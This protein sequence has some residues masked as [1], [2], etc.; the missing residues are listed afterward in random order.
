MTARRMY[1]WVSIPEMAQWLDLETNEAV[2]LL[3]LIGLRWR[4]A[5]EVRFRS[6]VFQDGIA[7]RVE[8]EDGAEA[9]QWNLFAIRAI[10]NDSYPVEGW[11][12][13]AQQVWC[14]DLARQLPF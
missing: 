6:D 5:G 14:L 3:R 11:A 1:E 13:Y 2:E 12:S 8:R 10:V 7:R 9:V 4:D